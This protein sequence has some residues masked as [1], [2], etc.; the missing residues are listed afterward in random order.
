MTCSTRLTT[1]VYGLYF[2]NN[3]VLYSHFSVVK[4]GRFS[5]RVGFGEGNMADMEEAMPSGKLRRCAK[6]VGHKAPS[7]AP[8]E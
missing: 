8:R 2:A 4:T 1:G 5:Q 3:I 6:R 7:T